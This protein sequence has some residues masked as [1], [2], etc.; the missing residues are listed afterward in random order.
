MTDYTLEI[1][2]TYYT[3]EIIYDIL[4][5]KII[6]ISSILLNIIDYIDYLK[7]IIYYILL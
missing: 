5:S 2:M 1:Y 6:Y 7:N 3:L 4:Y